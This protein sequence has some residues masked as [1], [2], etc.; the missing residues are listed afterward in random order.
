MTNHLIRVLLPIRTTD[1]IE[2]LSEQKDTLKRITITQLEEEL[3]DP[4]F[5]MMHSWSPT[6]FSGFRCLMR[7]KLSFLIFF[8]DLSPEAPEDDIVQEHLLKALPTSLKS[9][10]ITQCD[11]SASFSVMWA[12]PALIRNK[13]LVCPNLEEFKIELDYDRAFMMDPNPNGIAINARELPRLTG[14]KFEIT[15]PSGKPWILDEYP[16]AETRAECMDKLVEWGHMK[17]FRDDI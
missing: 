10:T 15:L 9:L 16:G 7:L 11:S 8:G 14:I 6:D 4:Q 1:I 12:Y 2:V 5:Q 13:D 17:P 3:R